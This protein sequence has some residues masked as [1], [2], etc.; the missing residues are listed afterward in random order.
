MAYVDLNPIRANMADSPETS[1]HTCVKYRIDSLEPNT[2]TKRSIEDFVGTNPNAKGHPFVLRDYLE[3]VDW[4]GR[5]IRGD[6]A[7]AITQALPLILKRL[8]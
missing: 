8:P 5:I 1:D 6:K 7:D 3:L 4:T 2:Q